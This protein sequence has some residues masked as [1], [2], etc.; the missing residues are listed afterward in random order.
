MRLLTERGQLDI[1]SDLSFTIEQNSPVFSSDGT[2]SIPV[3]IPATVRNL[4]VIDN[5][6]RLARKTQFIRKLSA[7]LEAG[8]IHKD[9]QLAIES[10]DNKAGIVAALM[11]NESDLYTKIKDLKLTDIFSKIIRND[12]SGAADPVTSWYNHIYNCMKGTINDDFTAFPVAINYNEDTGYEM[13]NCP[14]YT[15]AMDPW[16]LIF[17]ARSIPSGDDEIDV[18][19]GYGITP[20]LWMNKMIELLFAEYDYSVGDNPFSISGSPLKKVVILNNT[21]DTICPGKITYSDLVPDITVSEFI[22]FLGTKFAMHIYVSPETRQVNIK[23]IETVLYEDP[24]IDLTD[25][26]DG[27][28][29]VLPV[30]IQELD[31]SS[32]TSL[33]GATAAADTMFDLAKK[34]STV[35]KLDEAAWRSYSWGSL[36]A[37]QHHL[38]F[39]KATGE[40]WDIYFRRQNGEGPTVKERLGSNYF[41]YY[42]GRYSSKE[43]KSVDTIPPMVL[44]TIIVVDSVETNIMCPYIGQS[45][46]M[47][48]SITNEDN[49]TECKLI[50]AYAAGKAAEFSLPAFNAVYLAQASAKYYLGTIQKY[51]NAG[52]LW[53]TMDL[54]T[55]DLYPNLFKRWNSLLMNSAVDIECKVNYPIEKLL[56]LK[57]QKLKQINGQLFLPKALSYSVFSN[58]IEFGSSKFCLVKKLDPVSSDPDFPL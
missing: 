42:T 21:A 27:S 40:Y 30:D 6:T 33:E 41:R 51:D 11:F 52:N 14:D 58:K 31:I 8:I 55:T 39:R 45:R 18:P 37:Y 47:N 50:I 25:F 7:K 43:L 17:A 49:N 56:S 54:T 24:D 15:S 1:P 16:G 19:L 3:T 4:E 9:G 34:Y 35:T 29:K 26:V 32:D 5:P 57:M 48:T 36:P 23:Q 28:I 2:Q 13:L 10:A 44:S 46:H 12:Y 53:T 20:F 38:I 22:Q